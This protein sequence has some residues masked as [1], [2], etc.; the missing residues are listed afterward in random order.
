[1]K[2]CIT[3]F[4]NR[5]NNKDTALFFRLS[6]PRRTYVKILIDFFTICRCFAKAFSAFVLEWFRECF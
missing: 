5:H 3:V 1:M 4:F 6:T 2:D